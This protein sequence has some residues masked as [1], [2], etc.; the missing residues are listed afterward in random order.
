[1][2]RTSSCICMLKCLIKESKSNLLPTFTYV[3]R[4]VFSCSNLTA[5]EIV[6]FETSFNNQSPHLWLITHAFNTRDK[7]EKIASTMIFMWPMRSPTCTQ[8]SPIFFF[9]VWGEGWWGENFLSS[10]MCSH[11]VPIKFPP[12]FLLYSPKMFPITSHFCPTWFGQSWNF[13]YI[14]IYI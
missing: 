4:V 1:M 9:W 14:Y 2:L 12:R 8:E 3:S 6:E 5:N 13:I 7:V 10:P 11:Q